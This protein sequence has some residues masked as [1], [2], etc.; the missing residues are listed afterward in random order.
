MNTTRKYWVNTLLKI[1]TPVLN[2]LNGKKLKETMPVEG[3][4]TDR[5]AV[6]H[7]EALGRTLAGIAPWLETPSID[8]EEEAIRARTAE[9]ARSAIANA[10]DPESP[11]YLNFTGDTD[12]QPLVDAA[13]LAEGIIRAPKELWEKLDR[14]AQNNL[15]NALKL[16]RKIITYRHRNNWLLFPAMIEAAL[17][18]MTG[19]C[20]LTR[21]DYAMCMHEQWYKGDGVYGDGPEFH[22]DYYNSYVIQPMLLDVT[23]TL[24]DVLMR[25]DYGETAEALF[26]SRTRRYAAILER[27]IAADGTFPAI[28]RSIT[29]RTGA[30]HALAQMALW[31]E[32]PDGV[33]P[34]QVRCA[35]TAVI[36]KCFEAK[37]TFDRNG[38]LTIGLCGHQPSLGEY[39]ISTGSLY[40]CTFVF[41]PLGL[42]ADHPFWKDPDEPYTAIKIW[43]G[44]NSD[45]LPNDGE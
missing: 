11:D 42:P 31:N 21:V 40:L 6:T 23:R 35:L 17:Y 4:L 22:W 41:L 10:V 27:M 7:L 36:K 44:T 45:S 32:L 37:G 5:S 1:A 14:T 12:D 38:W 43:N 28:G 26:L 39:Y 8:A 20:D 15:V 19:E 30:F 34:A 24:K 16:T 25:N 2:A 18:R 9:L 13:F 3:K 33:S 29:Y